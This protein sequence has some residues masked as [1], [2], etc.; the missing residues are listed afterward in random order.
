IVLFF[1]SRRRHTRSKR[2][3]SSD[4][5]SSDLGYELI[6]AAIKEDL[7]IIVLP[8]ANAALCA[9]VGSGLSST[10]FHFYGFLPRKKKEKQAEL[11]RL[12]SIQATLLLYESPFRMKDTL[13]VIHEQ[14][15]NR[16]IAIGRELT[17]R[18]EEFVR[19][20]VEEL[21][22]WA[23]KTELKGEFCLVIEGNKNV[24]EDTEEMWWSHLS[25]KDHVTYY[26]Q[27][28]SLSSKEAIK[29]VMKERNMPKRE[30][31]SAYHLGN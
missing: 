23:K 14:L 16:N 31:Y 21:M 15:G 10:E 6:Q 3:W 25:V 7:P 1:S 22:D 17:K 11:K 12:S 4:V 28:Q 30:V 5:C 8:G 24:F 26:V 27:E 29:L 19:G 20:T 9:L 2:D 13:K 18:F